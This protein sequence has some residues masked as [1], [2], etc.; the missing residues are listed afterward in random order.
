MHFQ[1]WPAWVLVL[2]LLNCLI[3]H[4]MVQWEGYQPFRNGIPATTIHSFQQHW[5]KSSVFNISDEYVGK[6]LLQVFAFFLVKQGARGILEEVEEGI[7]MDLRMGESIYVQEIL[8]FTFTLLKFHLFNVAH[9]VSAHIPASQTEWELSRIEFQMNLFQNRP[10]IACL[11]FWTG[12]NDNSFFKKYYRPVWNMPPRDEMCH[13]NPASHPLPQEHWP[14]L[15]G[16][17]AQRKEHG[18]PQSTK[19][20]EKWS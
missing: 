19:V 12:C 10:V 11:L 8:G 13:S 14:A 5:V 9:Y 6:S 18:I 3:N 15:G 7:T 4:H 1:T 17:R 20:D 16:H 2:L